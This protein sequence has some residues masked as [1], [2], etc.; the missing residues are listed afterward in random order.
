MT[1]R[2]SSRSA[3]S[4]TSARKPARTGPRVIDP[5]SVNISESGP[6]GTV[7]SGSTSTTTWFLE[8]S[9]GRTTGVD[10]PGDGR[11]TLSH[12]E[13]RIYA[14]KTAK[15]Y[16][17]I[18]SNIVNAWS[19]RTKVVDIGPSRKMRRLK[20]EKEKLAKV[21]S[22]RIA[23]KIAARAFATKPIDDEDDDTLPAGVGIDF[24]PVYRS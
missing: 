7:P 15:D 4:T 20:E 5:S 6:S 17:A 1:L 3:S 18:F 10:L 8:D 14:S 24:E 11:M 23:E 13:C 16:E 9:E 12:G 19:H 2:T 21:N 22:E